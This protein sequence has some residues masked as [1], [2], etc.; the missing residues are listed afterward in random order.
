MDAKEIARER[1][2]SD[3]YAVKETFKQRL[4]VN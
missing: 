1:I 2:V 4:K 3:I